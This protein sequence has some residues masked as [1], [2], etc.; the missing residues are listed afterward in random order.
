[1]ADLA[2]KIVEAYRKSA[3]CLVG[4]CVKSFL[5]KKYIV[6][7]IAAQ[8]GLKIP[9]TILLGSN[10][11]S[12]ASQIVCV[13]ITSSILPQKLKEVVEEVLPVTLQKFRTTDS[14]IKDDYVYVD[15]EP[16]KTLKPSVDSC[17]LDACDLKLL[18][19]EESLSVSSESDGSNQDNDDYVTVDL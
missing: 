5:P 17:G 12:L 14:E 2:F 4:T 18:L 8:L 13:T 9:V 10:I 11:S 7:V 6:T 3:V 16:D 15:F 1:M 19:A